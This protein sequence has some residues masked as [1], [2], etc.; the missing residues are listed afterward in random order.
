LGNSK[1]DISKSRTIQELQ[2]D[3]SSQYPFLKLEFYKTAD[4]RPSVHMKDRIPHS[5]TLRSAGLTNAGMM[6]ITDDLTVGE[7]EKMFLEQFGLIVQVSRNSG[8]IWLETTMTDK[9][10]LYKQN[11][12]GREIIRQ[13]KEQ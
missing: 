7:L 10:S 4:V 9:W 3:F 11:E 5:T 2:Q 1:L 8:G 6:E 12:Y 13:P